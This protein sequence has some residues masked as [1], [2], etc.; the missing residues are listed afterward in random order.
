MTQHVDH[1]VVRGVESFAA[2]DAAAVATVSC[3]T[4]RAVRVVDRAAAAVPAADSCGASDSFPADLPFVPVAGR[5]ADQTCDCHLGDGTDH[6]VVPSDAVLG[7]CA[8][9]RPAFRTRLSVG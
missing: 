2:D 9:R 8:D 3:H 5:P 7:P 6:P 4:E 1:C